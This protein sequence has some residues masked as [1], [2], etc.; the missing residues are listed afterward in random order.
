MHQLT[1]RKPI[2]CSGIGLHS[3]RKVRL[4][5]RPAEE[6]SG[7]VFIVKTSSGEKVLR[8]S[9]DSVVCT[10]LA[11][12][13]GKGDSRIAT[14]EHL[15]AAIRG[16]GIDNIIVETEGGE[17]PIMDG[18][19]ASFVLLLKN[20]GIRKQ[21]AAK[22]VWA[23]KKEIV[24]ERDGKSIT[25]KP[26]NGFAVHYTIDFTHPMVGRQ[27]KGFVQRDQEFSR[28]IAKAR[29]FG[30]L[31]DV[32][33]LQKN[34]LALGGSLENAVVLDEYGVVNPEGLRFDDEFVRHKILDFIGDMALLDHPLWGSFQVFC[35]GH[36]VNNEFLRYLQD[37]AEDYLELLVLDGVRTPDFVEEKQG[38]GFPVWA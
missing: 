2:T 4:S 1:I 33:Y 32:E 13:L 3:G 28:Q 11:T 14:V 15:F 20:A 21:R 29:T 17:I 26:F 35:S 37:H 25:A 36:A 5:I 8:P 24:F 22:K 16:M 27:K 9:P 12:T 18:S 38:V 23:L 6:D 10:G 19:A 30:F 31:K 7:I 34:G